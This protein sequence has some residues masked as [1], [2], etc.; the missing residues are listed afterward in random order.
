MTIFIINKRKVLQCAT[1]TDVTF[2]PL[3]TS[4]KHSQEEVALQVCN[5]RALSADLA[6]TFSAPTCSLTRNTSFFLST[7]VPAISLEECV[8]PASRTVRTG[9]AD[10]PLGSAQ[11]FIW[12]VVGPTC[13]SSL[14]PHFVQSRAELEL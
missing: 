12:I 2:L 8:T 14:P 5:F 1:V 4:S 10:G 3:F 11:I 6:C 9:P 7:K 13:H